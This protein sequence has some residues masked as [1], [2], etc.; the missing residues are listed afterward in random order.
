MKTSRS[1][2]GLIFAAFSL[3]DSSANM[4]EDGKSKSQSPRLCKCHITTFTTCKKQRNKKQRQWFRLTISISNTLASCRECQGFPYSHFS[5]MGIMLADIS[6]SSLGY[7]LI[8]AVT[9]VC[10]PSRNLKKEFQFLSW[11]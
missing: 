9:V 1:G 5:Y 6:C 8:H 3:L 2:S 11:I 4:S 10:H 7:K